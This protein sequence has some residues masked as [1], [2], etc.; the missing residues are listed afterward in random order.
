MLRGEGGDGLGMGV[1]DGLLGLA[2]DPRPGIALRQVHGLGQ[3]LA[4]QA[5]LAVGIGP[6]TG[7]AEALD[8]LAVGFDHGD[9]DPVERGPAHQTEC[10]QHHC[11]E[12][13]EP[14]PGTHGLCQRHTSYNAT[15]ADEAAVCSRW[16]PRRLQ[17]A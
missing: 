1:R 12:P 14:Y 7:R 3:R 6:V 16:V 4:Q 5:A 17:L 11:F 8:P 15:A 2:Q 10:R 13:R 9:V